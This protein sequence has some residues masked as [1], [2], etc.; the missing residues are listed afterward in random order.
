MG[1]ASNQWDTGVFQNLI[2][3]RE[4]A[5]TTSVMIHD[6]TKINL[7][8]KEAKTSNGEKYQMLKIKAFRELYNGTLEEDSITLF[9][10]TGEELDIDTI[11]EINSGDVA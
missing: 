11:S 10:K 3:T 6:V 4:N 7:I 5:M 8:V 9:T 1:C 2:S